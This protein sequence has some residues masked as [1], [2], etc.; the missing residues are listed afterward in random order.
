M[1]RNIVR[2]RALQLRVR[3]IGHKILCGIAHGRG[4]RNTATEPGP[5]K[6][7]AECTC[8]EL[9]QDMAESG[10]RANGGET[11]RRESPPAT[12]ESFGLDKDGSARLQQMAAVP[13][14]QFDAALAEARETQT[15]ITSTSVRALTK[16]PDFSPS[17]RA[18]HERLWRVHSA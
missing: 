12:L 4:S 2:Y 8:G 3:K 17:Q 15:P 18:D 9:L 6:V 5:I 14:K 7:R 13:Q 16:Q 10:E 1:I 11:G